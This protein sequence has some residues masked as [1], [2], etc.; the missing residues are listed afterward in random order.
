MASARRAGLNGLQQVI[1]RI[2]L[3]GLEGM[4]EFGQQVEAGFTG[5]LYVQKNEVGVLAGDF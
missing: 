2:D 4:I 3:K 1:Q 5:H